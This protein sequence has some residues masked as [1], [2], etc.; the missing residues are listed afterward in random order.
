MS[1]QRGPFRF[2]FPPPLGI[3]HTDEMIAMN[4]YSYAF[5]SEQLGFPNFGWF[6]QVLNKNTSY[7]LYFKIYWGNSIVKILC[8]Q[9]DFWF[10][11]PAPLI[12]GYHIFPSLWWPFIFW[13]RN[14]WDCPLQQ[15]WGLRTRTHYFQ[16]NRHTHKVNKS[17]MH[18]KIKLLKKRKKI[19]EK[20]LYFI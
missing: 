20:K 14:K 8:S 5:N 19:K 4:M 1:S 15:M 11:V 18:V 2:I 16:A 6:G 17:W 12:T 9:L 3:I 13:S 7:Q 10:L